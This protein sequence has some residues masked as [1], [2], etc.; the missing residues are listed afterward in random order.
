MTEQEYKDKLDAFKSSCRVYKNEKRMLEEAELKKSYFGDEQLYRF[1]CEDVEY[2]DQMFEKIS[3]KCGMN[4]R[5]MLW[6]LFV[7]E[8]TQADVAFRFGLSRRQL[9]YSMNKW[10]RTVLSGG[11]SQ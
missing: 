2:V 10:M 6:L 5:L 7:E 1:M 3:E 4:A 11:E 9:Q 8:N